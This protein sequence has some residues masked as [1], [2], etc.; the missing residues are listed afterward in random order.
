MQI[1]NHVLFDILPD[2]EAQPLQLT[3]HKNL[4]IEDLSDPDAI[5]LMCFSRPQLC[6]LHTHF[7]IAGLL[8]PGDD[9]L[10][11]PIPTRWFVGNTP[12]QYRVH[13][14]EALL[15]TMIKVATGMTT[16]QFI[17]DNYIGGVYARWS[18]IYPWMIRYL[19]SL[20]EG[21][22]G[23]GGLAQF[24]DQFPCFHDAIERYERIEKV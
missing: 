7:A 8:D 10:R 4:R 11:I 14:E 6:E 5:R 16:H 2:E 9:K 21:I 3:P 19:L 12:C 20:Y 13:P 18:K 24:V 17:A 23:Y 15:F 22:L 1:F